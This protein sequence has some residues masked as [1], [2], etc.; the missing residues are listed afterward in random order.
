VAIE[1]AALAAHVNDSPDPQVAANHLLAD[2][3]ILFFDQPKVS[4]FAI[5]ALPDDVTSA[6]LA[7]LLD[8][9]R[10]TRV[11]RPMPISTAFATVPVAGARGEP[12]GRTNPL[13]RTVTAS[14]SS[15]GSFP[16]RLRSAEADLQSYTG[17]LDAND[18]HVSA[19]QQRL[20][21]AGAIGL[22]DQQRSAYIDG[23]Q[24]TVRDEL[25]KVSM[26]SRQS[27]TFT[28]RDGVVSFMVHNAAGYPIH[29]VARLEGAKLEFPQH[30]DG[31]IPLTLAEGAT[32]LEIDVRT[33]TSGDSPL[34]VTLTTPDGR[35]ELGRTRVTI[36]STAFS[37]VGLFLSIGAGLFLI[38]WW[39]RHT[40]E[41][42][43]ASQQ[44]LR[45]AVGAGRHP[46]QRP[47]A[48]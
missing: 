1:D 5:V 20:L 6:T 14:A 36:R 21:V 3:A 4:R 26:P 11:F 41:T 17:S 39:A 7:S 48:E 15:L 35:V 43:R 9:L 37:G 30:P 38:V 18:A 13:T 46:S 33:L 8:G 29:T 16:S 42:R 34:D 10:S 23:V 19:L 2:L 12:D 32:R 25:H 27:I 24:R 47:N 28:A 31:T 40:A 22:S 45:H 44:R